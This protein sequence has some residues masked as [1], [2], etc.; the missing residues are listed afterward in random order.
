M[1]KDVVKYLCKKYELVVLT[2]W[3]TE[4]QKERL[5]NYKIEPYFKNVIGTDFIL[6]KP[7]KESFIYACSPY[8][9][10]KC[11]MIGDSLL[12]DINGALNAGMDA[13]LFDFKNE[14]KGNIKKVTK[15]EELKDIL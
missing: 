8:D 4:Q 6:N 10:S 15:I 11:I 12:K 13:I 14:Y 1:E 5:K 9:P 3:F 2:N 7:N